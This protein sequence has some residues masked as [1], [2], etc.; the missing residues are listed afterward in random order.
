ML[1]ESYPSAGPGLIASLANAMG[2]EVI[3]GRLTLGEPFGTGYIKGID[4]GSIKIMVCQC[5]LKEHLMLKRGAAKTGKDEIT[6]SFRHVIQEISAVKKRLLPSV[7]VSSADM[8]LEIFTPAH[9]KVNT[10]T[11]TLQ[12]ALIQELL[13]KQAGNSLLQ[14]IISGSQP[15]FYDEIVS[16][17]IQQVAARIVEADVPEPLGDF[18]L[19]LKAEELIYLFFVS[20]LKRQHVAPYPLNM[21]DVKVMY[22]IRD[23]LMADLSVPPNLADLTLFSNMSESKMNRLF[24]QIFGNSIYHYYQK[25]RMKEAAFL[26]KE[27]NLSVSE[28]GYSLGFSNL[29]HFTRLFEKHMGIKPKKYSA[30]K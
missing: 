12:A 11:I 30:G 13:N 29:S 8:A 22:L 2:S 19:K 27:Q 21:A 17:E 6:F 1:L 18:Y 10:I 24:K 23:K 5:E 25:L 7:Q 28:A 9:T 26:I 20:L 16:P 14:H 15:Y 3:Q 4:L